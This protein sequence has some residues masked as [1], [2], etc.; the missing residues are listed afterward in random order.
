MCQLFVAFSEYLNFN[1]TSK[2]IWLY[3]V[4]HRL[5]QEHNSHQHDVNYF[6]R[7]FC[8]LFIFWEEKNREILQFLKSFGP[9][10]STIDFLKNII[11]THM[12][13]T[14]VVCQTH[15]AQAINNLQ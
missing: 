14:F 9:I 15:A 11:H 2:D 7:C 8:F 12:I 10:G 3:W 13:I 6:T 4:H 1:A 5:P